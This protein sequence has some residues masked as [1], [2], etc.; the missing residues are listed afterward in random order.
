MPTDDN[1]HGAVKTGK[2]ADG[3]GYD[4]RMLPRLDVMVTSSFTGWTNYMM[5]F[6]KMLKDAE[7]MK[8]FGNTFAVWRLSDRKPLKIFDVPG[9]P[10]EIRFALDPDKDYCFTAA[11]LT[12]KIWLIYRDEHG[13]WQAQEV[14]DIGDPAKVPLP[15]AFSKS[16]DDRLLWVTTF[17]EYTPLMLPI[18]F[19]PSR[20]MKNELARRSTWSPPVGTDNGC[21][22]P[23]HC[24]P[25]GIK[26]GLKTNSISKA[27]AGM[28]KNSKRDLPLISPR[29]S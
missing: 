13:E 1:L 29:R 9:A 20:S 11:A 18:P 27:S 28:A 7:A 22:S 16:S 2:Y 8:R 26:R 3:Y 14:A 23:V 25:S 5:D 19:I 10:L 17:M 4:V 12:S 21:T 24:F 15:V 6:G